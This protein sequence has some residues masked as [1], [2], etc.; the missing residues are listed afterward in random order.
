[1]LKVT[2]KGGKT[3]EGEIFA[4][5]PVSKSLVLKNEEIFSIVNPNQIS[6]ID[7][8]VALPTSSSFGQFSVRWGSIFPSPWFT[9]LLFFVSHSTASLEKKEHASLKQAEKNMAALNKNVASH[10]QFLYDRMNSYF[11]C[12]W[13]NVNIIVLDEYIIEPP[14]E[15]L[16]LLPGREG[17]GLERVSKR[18]SRYFKFWSGFVNINMVFID[19]WKK[20]EENWSC[21]RE[22]RKYFMSWHMHPFRRNKTISFPSF[23]PHPPSLTLKKFFILWSQKAVI[24]LRFIKFVGLLVRFFLECFRYHYSPNV[25][26][27]QYR[28]HNQLI[29]Q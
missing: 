27:H 15:S 4:I 11:P 25:H 19:S 16:K 3:Y 24:L 9:L 23:S 6:H 2:T 7:G 17:S 29:Q 12:R 28:Y 20:N 8:N 1:M 18:V 10:V 22:T 5:D 21:N 13:E 14:Y 26:Y